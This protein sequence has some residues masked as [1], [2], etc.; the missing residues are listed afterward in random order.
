MSLWTLCLWSLQY[1][2]LT[3]KF[4][5]F[6]IHWWYWNLLFTFHWMCC[7]CYVLGLGFSVLRPWARVTFCFCQLT[8]VL[9]SA[10]VKN[11][12]PRT[13]QVKLQLLAIIYIKVMQI[14]DTMIVL[15]FGF[16]WSSLVNTAKLL[17]VVNTISIQSIPN[18]YTTI[19]N[20]VS[21]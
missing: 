18:I 14:H 2:L 19:S 9:T 1:Y 8:N 15:Q 12:M 16:V 20:T 11:T 3:L 21:M 4:C 17:A 5:F 6:Q 7:L 13:F 10:S